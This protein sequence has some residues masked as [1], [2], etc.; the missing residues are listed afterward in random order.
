MYYKLIREVRDGK[1]VR[2]RICRVSHYINKRTGECVERLHPICETLENADY[3]IPALIYK[4]QV[5]HSPKFGKL[6]PIL[7][8]VPNRTGIRIHYGT[9]PEHSKGCILIPNQD[10]CRKIVETLL[11]EQRHGREMFVE[12]KS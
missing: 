6:L 4:I 11:D 5:T 8:Q 1:S 9:K 10:E 12:V 3:L 2:G 7:L